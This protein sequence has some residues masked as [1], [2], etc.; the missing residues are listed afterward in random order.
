[1]HTECTLYQDALYMTINF[2]D[3][4]AVSRDTCMLI[5]L[6]LQSKV[7]TF[8]CWSQ[9]SYVYNAHYVDWI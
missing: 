8:D 7:I 2:H 1:M 9:L 5:R 3:C 4:T 6:K